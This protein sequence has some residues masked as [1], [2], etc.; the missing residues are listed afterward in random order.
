MIKQNVA[1]FIFILRGN[2]HNNSVAVTLN[3]K[4]VKKDGRADQKEKHSQQ[5]MIFL[6]V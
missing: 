5:K 2:V 3:M 1:C 6:R 4:L